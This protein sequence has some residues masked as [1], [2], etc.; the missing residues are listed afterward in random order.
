MSASQVH[1]RNRNWL[2]AMAASPDS[3]TRLRWRNALVE[4]NLGLVKLVA[5][6]LSLRSGQPFDELVSAGNMGLIR[7]VEAFDLRQRCSLS[8][9]AVP[10]IQGAM[11]HDQRD[12]G[13]P[14]R[15][16]RRL[17]EL[18]QRAR[19]LQE[20]RRGQGLAPLTSE[21]LASELDCRTSQL[22]EAGAV[23]RAL[24]VRSLDA[25]LGSDDAGEPCCLLDQLAAQGPAGESTG[26][27]GDGSQDRCHWLRSQLDQL[28]G[29][30]RRLLEGR[31][32]EG[33]SWRELGLELRLTSRQA[34]QRAEALLSW[35]QRAAGNPAANAMASRAA[36][37]V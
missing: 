16:P 8:S 4:Q 25:P 5:Q 30:E 26:E 19:R 32:L 14:L 22:A 33:R 34:Q 24:Q 1:A 37:A 17:R 7:A 2:E 35:L 29:P 18:L 23:E 11:L 10:Y 28:D 27:L 12:N 6:R 3:Q 13:Q 21:A 31:W 36:M 20:Q 9:F 15:T